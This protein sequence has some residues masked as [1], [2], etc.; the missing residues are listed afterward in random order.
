M[1]AGGP[2]GQGPFLNTLFP[3][4]ADVRTD[5]NALQPCADCGIFTQTLGAAPD[6]Q[7]VIRWKTTYFDFAGR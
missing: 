4:Y 5:V 6:R 2:V 1:R 3:Y 7:I